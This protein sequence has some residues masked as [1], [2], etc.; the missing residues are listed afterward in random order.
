MSETPQIEHLRMHAIQHLASHWHRYKMWCTK[1][2]VPNVHCTL[3]KFYQGVV[4]GDD[5]NKVR[6]HYEMHYN[7]GSK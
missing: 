4:N 3:E 1:A 6:D 2:H 5:L 7:K